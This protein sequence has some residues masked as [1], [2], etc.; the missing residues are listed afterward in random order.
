MLPQ[1]MFLQGGLTPSLVRRDRRDR[2][3]KINII[4]IIII[5]I[6]YI[7]MM[8][9]MILVYFKSA[10]WITTRTEAPA[11]ICGPFHI[12]LPYQN[13]TNQVYLRTQEQ[14]SHTTPAIPM[15]LYLC[16]NTIT[17]YYLKAIL[18]I[19]LLLEINNEV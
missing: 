3:N 8:M 2:V 6:I 13:T 14:V 19:L 1:V 16:C 15:S 5:I 12:F 17:I 7:Y 9:M 4:I 10:S 11:S 18:Y